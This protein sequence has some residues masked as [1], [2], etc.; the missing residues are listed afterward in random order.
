MCGD[1]AQAENLEQLSDDQ[2]ENAAGG[3]T[4][5][6]FIAGGIAIGWAANE[7]TD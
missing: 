3:V 2:L 7:L 4:P 6:L 5:G 1:P